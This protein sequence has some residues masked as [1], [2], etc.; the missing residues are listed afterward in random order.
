MKNSTQKNQVR[1]FFNTSDGWKGKFY[2]DIDNPFGQMLV[3]RKEHVL[4][5]VGRY[6]RKENGAI[7]DAGCGPGEYLRELAGAGVQL[8]GMDASE[9]M[10]GSAVD[11]LRENGWSGPPPLVRGDIEN[12]PFRDAS[13]SAVICIGVIGYLHRDERAISEMGRLLRPGGH[14][15]LNV[16]N[17]NALTSW[18][19]SARLKYK[20]LIRHGWRRFRECVSLATHTRDGGWTSRAYDIRRLESLIASNGFERIEGVTFGYELRPLSRLGVSGGTI[21]RME[22]FLERMMMAVPIRRLGRAGWGYIGVFR[23]TGG[24]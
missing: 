2:R 22:R 11:T 20:Y 17:L 15:V 10:L 5:L 13:F 14:L 16:R 12:I 23:K 18:H 3:R 6:I 1:D 4:R 7:F 8:V 21:V 19:Y 24:G 9:V